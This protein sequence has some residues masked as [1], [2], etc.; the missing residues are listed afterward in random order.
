MFSVIRI[1]TASSPRELEAVFRF[2]YLIYVEE[3]NRVQKDADHKARRIE[4]KLD[5]AG[6]NL[7]AWENEELVGVVRINFARDGNLGF[8]EHFY[9]MTGV[10]SDHPSRTSIDTRLMVVPRLRHTRLPLL[11]ARACYCHALARD[12]RWNFI[13]C[14]PH[15][16]SFFARLGYRENL[17]QGR[18]DEYGMVNRM[19]LDLEDAGYL[20]EIGSPFLP[21]WQAIRGVPD[22]SSE[23]QPW[24][25][26]RG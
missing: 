23:P 19:R 26:S 3:M 20:A 22:R 4:D 2:R 25:A 24:R 17:P 15:L 9:N 12:I 5:K 11:L 14:N 21:D 8:Y 10:G 7:V 6:T 13:D 16:E 1:T 18:H